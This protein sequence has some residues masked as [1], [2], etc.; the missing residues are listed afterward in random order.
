[1]RLETAGWNPASTF[2][3]MTGVVVL[4]NYNDWTSLAVLTDEL[5]GVF[6]ALPG[7]WMVLVVDDAS[8]I[9]RPKV[10]TL[11]ESTASA[12]W[13]IRDTKPPSSMG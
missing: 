1:M 3:N 5:Q 2:R 8:V 7:T 11:K 10:G 6:A 4:P 12:L 9:P 13:P